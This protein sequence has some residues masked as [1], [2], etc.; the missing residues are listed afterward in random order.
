MNV[1]ISYKFSLCLDSSSVSHILFNF[2]FCLYVWNMSHC[3]T[4]NR[5]WISL[6]RAHLNLVRSEDARVRFVISGLSDA[7]T[8]Q[9]KFVTVSSCLVLTLFY[10]IEFSLTGTTQLWLSDGVIRMDFWSTFLWWLFGVD[11]KQNL[12]SDILFNITYTYHSLYLSL[13]QHLK[14]CVWLFYFPANQIIRFNA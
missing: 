5:L 9:F 2:E 11:G 13:K 14:M 3:D 10:L 8:S 12:C 7:N 4:S 1:T 6:T